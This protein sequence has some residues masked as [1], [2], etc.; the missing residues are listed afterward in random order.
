EKG[1]IEPVKALNS[2]RAR[3]QASDH[4][5]RLLANTAANWGPMPGRER[6]SGGLFRTAAGDPNQPT[7]RLPIRVQPRPRSSERTS[8]SS[9]ACERDKEISR[10]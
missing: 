4:L 6:R 8:Q 5:W 10:S 3:R 1:D 2:S 7:R 9:T